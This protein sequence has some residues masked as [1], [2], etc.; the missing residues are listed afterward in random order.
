MIPGTDNALT[1]LDQ[2]HITPAAGRY[3]VQGFTQELVQPAL[4]TF[5]KS[6]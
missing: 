3:V 1:T 5:V 4:Q 2:D 6:H